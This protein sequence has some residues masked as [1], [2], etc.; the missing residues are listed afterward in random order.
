MK[1][2]GRIVAAFALAATFPSIGQPQDT[3]AG[4]DMNTER[5]AEEADREDRGEWGWIGLLGLA[6]LL[7]LKRRETVDTR[8]DSVVTPT[9]RP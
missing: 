7:G 4:Q 9:P 2:T 1:R 6:G 8:R 3:A 5:M